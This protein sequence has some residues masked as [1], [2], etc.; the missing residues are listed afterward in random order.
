MAYVKKPLL[1]PAIRMLSL[2]ALVSSS[3]IP[4]MGQTQAAPPPSPP[5]A[6]PA[7]ELP[8]LRAGS[9]AKAPA[10]ALTSAEVAL[11]LATF[12]DQI[13]MGIQMD[14]LATLQTYGTTLFMDNWQRQISPYFAGQDR[15]WQDFFRNATVFGGRIQGLRGVIIFYN[16]WS[17]TAMVAG[18]DLQDETIT[19][20][21][22]MAGERLR[23]DPVTEKSVKPA[24]Y[25][26]TGR[27]TEI[28]GRVYANTERAITVLYPLDAPYSVVSDQLK[29]RLGSQQAELAPVKARMRDRIAIL[30]TLTRPAP[31][32]A[33]ALAARDLEAIS[34][35]L[36]QNDRIAFEKIASPMQD[37]QMTDVLFEWPAQNRMRLA[38]IYYRVEDKGASAALASPFSPLWFVYVRLVDDSQGHRQIGYA[39][40]YNL[41][42]AKNLLTESV[43]SA[44]PPQ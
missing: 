7:M 29:K 21:F 5:V 11:K 14:L 10:R 32:S 35:H 2:I 37:K 23:A 20:F 6:S 4:R 13:R 31:G 27:L 44:I 28:I 3:M 42:I 16:P 12:A 41:N 1:S 19:D 25:A 26:E 30:D 9:T 34:V 40:L 8:S 18:A 15:Q 24:W 43:R 39:T 17:D 38:P 22:I 36:R 33:D